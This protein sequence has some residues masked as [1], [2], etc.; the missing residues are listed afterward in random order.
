M[1]S[2][3]VQFSR[4]KRRA[5]WDGSHPEQSLLELTKATGLKPQYACRASVCGTC[6]TR[7]LGGSVAYQ[8]EPTA[9]VPPGS[10]LICI[11]RP[12]GETMKLDQ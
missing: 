11:A 9:E 2:A 7:V 6:T 12:T 5:T 10:T 8:A 1:S 4:S 3:E